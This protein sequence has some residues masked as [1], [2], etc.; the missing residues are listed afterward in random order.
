M[1][2]GALGDGDGVLRCGTVVDMA[3]LDDQAGSVLA[4]GGSLLGNIYGV[5]TAGQAQ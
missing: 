1:L 5:T 2:F 3:V 4:D